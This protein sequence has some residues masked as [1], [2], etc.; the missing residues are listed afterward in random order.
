MAGAFYFRMRSAMKSFLIHNQMHDP[1]SMFKKILDLANL[2]NGHACVSGKQ[3][4]PSGNT[5][6]P[7]P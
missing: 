3:N 6:R 7:G 5:K 4:L 2:T 1:K